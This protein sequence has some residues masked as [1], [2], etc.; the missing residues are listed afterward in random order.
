V[1]VNEYA[2]RWRVFVRDGFTCQ[3]CGQ[4]A[5]NVI[6]HLEHRVEVYEGG[7]SSLENLTTACSACNHGKEL[8]MRVTRARGGHGGGWTPGRPGQK[9]MILEALDK[10]PTT[11]KS[12]AVQIAIPSATVRTV[13]H[14]LASTGHVV[15]Y[16]GIWSRVPL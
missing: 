4:S 7:P 11:I 10:A 6:L 12:L 15:N 1:D 8:V 9:T 3:Y 14:R 16:H 5:P 13:L 2:L